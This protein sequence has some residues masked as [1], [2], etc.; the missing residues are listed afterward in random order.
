MNIILKIWCWLAIS[1]LA[2]YI[3]GLYFNV[4]WFYHFVENLTPEGRA[5]IT[6]FGM[7]GMTL[8][9]INS[10]VEALIVKK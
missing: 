1:M 2:V 5:I 6:G 8:L 7:I 10:K 9:Q 3:L 4:P